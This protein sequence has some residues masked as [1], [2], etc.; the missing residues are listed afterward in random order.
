[1]TNEANNT[2]VT[3]AWFCCSLPPGTITHP[4]QLQASNAGWLPAQVPGTVASALAQVGDWNLDQPLDADANDWWFR[5]T[6]SGLQHKRERPCHLCFDGLAT[7]AEIWLNGQCLLTTNNMFRS[8]RLDVTPQLQ[9]E[10]ELVLGFRS[11]TQALAQKRPRPRWK[12]KL[13]SHQQ[14]RWHRTTLLGRIPGWSPPV[15]TVGPWRDVRLESGPVIVSDVR[16][17]STLQGTTGVV[18]LCVRIDSEERVEQVTL[19]VGEYVITV[20][21]SVEADSRVWQAE[22]RVP[23]PQLW[24][25]HT[26]GEQALL[27]CSLEI[28]CSGEHYDVPCGTIGFR[29]V[30]VTPTDRLEILVNG[31][32]IYC[33]GACWTVDNITTLD[34]SLESLTRDLTLARD[35]GVNILRVG[36]TMIY[37]SDYFYRLCDELGILVWQD[38]MFANQDYPVEDPDFSANI[39]AEAVEQLGR[40]ARH[41][42]VAVYCGNSEVEQQAAMLGMPENV[43]RNRWFGEQLPELCAKYHAGTLYL[44]STPSGGV[45]PFHSRSGVSHYYGIGAYLRSPSDLRK[46]DVAFSSEC[47]GFANIPDQETLAEIADGD[48]LMAHHPLW[49]QRVPRDTG[50]GWDFDDVRDFY[51]N[52]L[53]GVDPVQLRSFDP[54]RYMQLSRVVPGA[55][56]SQTFSE[57]RRPTSNNRGGIVWFFKDLWPGAGWGILDSKS[58]PKACYYALRRVWQPL[59]IIVTDEGLEGLHLHVCNETAHDFRGFVELVLL[60]SER[61]IVARHEVAC[62]VAARSAQTLL[63]DA[64]LQG[65]RDVTYAYRFG[66]PQHD[67]AIATLLDEERQVVSEAHF[68]PT[69]RV[70]ALLSAVEVHAEAEALAD[71]SYEVSLRSDRFLHYLSL[72]AKGFLPDDNYFHLSP[73][74]P[75]KVRLASSGTSGKLKGYVE[76]LNLQHPV[77]ISLKGVGG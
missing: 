62:N 72:D 22:L 33:R 3:G 71:G 44:P 37:E 18:T 23:N 43:W 20:D 4:E 60:K 26:H 66:P 50:T 40:L 30:E 19:K 11:L 31:E 55:M 42:C 53:F 56:M 46:D 45:L 17:T 75:K 65:F 58:R 63:S 27:D 7:L 77:K 76:A 10:N 9:P 67:L 36:G 13:V 48:A 39:T 70:P 41:P 21:Q 73:L 34:G 61:I 8:Y 6:F 47:L 57:W 25:P 49:K 52:K 16:I 32:P 64:I 12:T 59:Q 29:R 35:A 69:P 68:F 28:V 5:T 38:F 14:L 1:M 24:W 15:P 2:R 51:L 74:R 54:T